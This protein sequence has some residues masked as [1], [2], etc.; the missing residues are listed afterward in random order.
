[1][2]VTNQ[3]IAAPG[4]HSRWKAFPH[5]SQVHWLVL[6][7][8]VWAIGLVFMGQMVGLK[9]SS[10]Q[11]AQG[12]VLGVRASRTTVPKNINTAPEVKGDITGPTVENSSAS[13]LL[14]SE[15]DQ[16]NVQPARNMNQ[17]LQK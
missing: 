12:E 14:P 11:L 16:L 10:K 15:I 13:Q 8:V 7:V 6:V 17:H 2:N 5:H 3:Q 4:W 9:N 1:M